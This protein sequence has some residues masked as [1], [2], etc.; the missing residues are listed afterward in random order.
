MQYK[1]PKDDSGDVVY[2]NV[3]GLALMM[4]HT[5]FL[6]ISN[7]SVSSSSSSS[8]SSLSSTPLEVGEEMVDAPVIQFYVASDAA[9]KDQ[10]PKCIDKEQ[11]ISLFALPAQSP[12]MKEYLKQ[13]ASLRAA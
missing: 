4:P 13:V 1:F 12:A 3:E 10:D 9:K 6:N 5:P 2:C 8:A 7:S 11:S